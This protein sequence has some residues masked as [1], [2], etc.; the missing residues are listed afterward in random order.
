[1][2]IPYYKP[3]IT[4]NEIKA[5]T[6]VMKSDFMASGPEVKELES[7][8][9]KYCGDQYCVAVSSATAGL[10]LCCKYMKLYHG[11]NEV[12]IP[13]YTFCATNQAALAAGLK[14]NICDVDDC[15]EPKV[16]ILENTIIVRFAGQCLFREAFTKELIDAAHCFPFKL[17][18]T[19]VYSFYPTKPIGANGGGMIVTPDKELADWC[20]RMRQHGRNESVGHAENPSGVGFNFFLSDLN[21]SIVR[22]QLKRIDYLKERRLEIANRYVE[23]LKGIDCYFGDHLFMVRFPEIK[24]ISS[25]TKQYYFDFLTGEGIG[26]SRPYIP[27][28]DR[29]KAPNAWNLYERS[30]S[31]PYYVSLTKR[32][33]K[34][35]IDTIRRCVK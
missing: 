23:G 21:A 19:R 8:Y 1:M 14:T 31:I 16:G 6:R 27:L 25:V 5:A 17:D 33:Q 13:A 11:W 34:Y 2:N 3:S 12:N 7:E 26:I 20:R 15:Y 18:N 30:I 28:A 35:I 29:D 32:D 22:E 24:N 10:F 9:S 4:A